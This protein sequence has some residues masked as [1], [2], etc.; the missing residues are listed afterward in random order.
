MYSII[1][2]RDRRVLLAASLQ[3]PVQK[4]LPGTEHVHCLLTQLLFVFSHGTKRDLLV[5]AYPS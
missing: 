3:V 5:Q 4:L 1:R 2:S